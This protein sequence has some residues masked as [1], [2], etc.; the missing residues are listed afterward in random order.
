M[1][2][3]ERVRAGDTTRRFVHR[4]I[5]RRARI[6]VRFV[7]TVR[8]C[9][10]AGTSTGRRHHPPVR[11]PRYPPA[12]G[13]HVRFV[14]TVRLCA[15]VWNEYWAGDTTR[16]FV[17]RGI[18]RRQRIHVR[19]VATVRLCAG[20]GTSTGRR[21]HPPVRSPRYP[22]ATGIHVRFVAT[23]RLCAGAHN[24]YWAGDTTR[25]F[26]HCGIHRRARIRVRFVATVRLCAG[27]TT[28]L[29]R[30]HLLRVRSLRCPPAGTIRVRFVATVRL[31]AGAGTS[32]GRRRLRRVR[33]LP[34]PSASRIRVRLVSTVRLCAGAG[35]SLGR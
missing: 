35:T 11:S 34:C 19:F 18:H 32:T 25:R 6:H 22:P 21:H 14:A 17:H 1:L 33:S 26:V 15:G 9:A 8:L 13:I 7:A 23:V 16:R 2:G 10:G 28:R 20:A 5:H 24:A 27:V 31:C 3:L 4:G 29:G 30:R 12:T